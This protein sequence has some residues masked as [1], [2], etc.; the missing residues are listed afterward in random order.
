MRIYI[1]PPYVIEELLVVLSDLI[2][3][4]TILMW[5]KIHTFRKR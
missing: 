5:P 4:V 1:A 2:E 3:I